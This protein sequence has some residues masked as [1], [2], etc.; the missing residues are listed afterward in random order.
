[1]TQRSSW[2]G[3]AVVLGLA[4]LAG[5]AGCSQST[6]QRTVVAPDDEG[7]EVEELEASDAEEALAAGEAAT[8]EGTAAV[9]DGDSLSVLGIKSVEDHGQTGVFVKLNRVPTEVKDFTLESPNRIVFDIAGPVEAA[10]PISVKTKGES[11]IS[12]IRVGHG[13]GRIRVTLDVAGEMPTYTMNNLDAMVVA[14]VGARAETGGAAREQVLYTKSAAPAAAG[15]PAMAKATI[16]ETPSYEEPKVAAPTTLRSRE[17]NGQK[18]SLDFKDADVQNVLRILAEV[19]DVNIVA[20][21]DVKG[22]ITLRLV[23]VP[24][25]QALDIV[26]QAARLDMVREGNVIRVSSVT[27]IKEEREA[28]LAAE[29]AAR[30]LEPLKTAYVRVNYLKVTG[31]PDQQ[32]NIASQALGDAQQVCTSQSQR[33]SQEGG[34]P[35]KEQVKKVLSERGDVTIDARSNTVIIRDIQRGIDAARELIAQLDV[36]TP[37]ILIESN[38]VEANDQYQRDL[39]IQWGYA[40]GIGP[41]FGT[42]TG[43]E[44]PASVALGGSGFPAG[45]GAPGTGPPA[46]AVPGTNTGGGLGGSGTGGSVP[47]VPVPFIANFPAQTV[48]AAAGSAFDISLGSIDGSKALNARI[49]ALER[50]GKVKI[51]SRPKV[52]TSNNEL[53]CI[54]SVLITRVRTPDAGTIVGGNAGANAFEEFI[55]GI[56]LNVV[57]QVSADGYILLQLRVVSSSAGPGGIDGIPATLSREAATTVLIKSGETLVLGGVFRDTTT[58]NERGIPYLRSLP[59]FGWLFKNSLIDDTREELLVFMT[60]KIIE[61]SV[62]NP[63]SLPT[64]QQLWST[65]QP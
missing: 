32:Q 60:P 42:S 54:A 24:W 8:K 25:D 61:G 10:P 21:D 26:L 14:F 20:T 39:G 48:S 17:F 59:V 27:R 31:R 28:A 16:T 65:Q 64:A 45:L 56:V 23:D 7:L 50:D 34:D 49:T 13:E 3:R 1:M 11:Q 15:G 63:T 33:S 19:G 47:T 18:I 58:D 43:Y 37:Q 22:R 53:A 40:Y 55:T 5:V 46:P 52:A 29:Q 35:L 38:I 9:A 2:R 36:P 51:I 41:Q 30:E 12:R 4:M 44:F 6:T 57:P 62:G